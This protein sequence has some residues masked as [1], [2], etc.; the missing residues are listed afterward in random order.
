MKIFLCYYEASDMALEVFVAIIHIMQYIYIVKSSS[1]TFNILVLV[2][3][4]LTN[5]SMIDGG[6]NYWTLFCFV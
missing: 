5:A 6:E 4:S 2:H 3:I 1:V